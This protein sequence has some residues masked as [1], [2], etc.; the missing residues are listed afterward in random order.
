MNLCK[1]S[2]LAASLIAASMLPTSARAAFTNMTGVSGPG[3]NG[4]LG[5]SPTID[6]VYL[7]FTSIKPLTASL[8]V[9]GASFVGTVLEGGSIVI[10]GTPENG[11]SVLNTTGTSW[12][13]FSIQISGISGATIIPGSAVE[14]SGFLPNVAED[15]TDT[16]ITFSG[17]SVA[18]N[19]SL[20][21]G[22]QVSVPSSAVG[23]LLLTE[24]PNLVLVS[25]PEPSSVVLVGLGLLGSLAYARSRRTRL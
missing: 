8:G 13:S 17:G 14:Q 23:N 11:G 18:N 12:T 2:L 5:N 10:N 24:T 25:V 9:D 7:Q 22:F 6:S 1:R 4:F 20:K 21:I 16:K 15:S 19:A 3:G